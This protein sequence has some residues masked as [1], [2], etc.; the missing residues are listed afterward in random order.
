MTRYTLALPIQTDLEQQH[1]PAASRATPTSVAIDLGNIQEGHVQHA[2]GVLVLDLKNPVTI[3][4]LLYSTVLVDL[5]NAGST[6][7]V[8]AI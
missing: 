6:V 3:G 5:A 2:D 7:A 8:N 1:V 4:G